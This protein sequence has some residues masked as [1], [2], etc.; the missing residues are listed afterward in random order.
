MKINLKI[1]Y[2]K[3][4]VNVN[5]KKMFRAGGLVYVVEHLPSYMWGPEFKSHAAKKRKK[6]KFKEAFSKV[7]IPRFQMLLT[8]TK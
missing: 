7:W 2:N 3:F 8:I 1:L 4:Q 6:K 5:I